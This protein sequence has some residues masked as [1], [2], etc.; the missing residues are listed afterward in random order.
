MKR[1]YLGVGFGFAIGKFKGL[2]KV[3]KLKDQP[4]RFMQLKD[5][6]GNVQ[7]GLMNL[8]LKENKEAEW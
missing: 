1:S 2:S 3:E 6:G 5:K 8:T 7:Q 4:C